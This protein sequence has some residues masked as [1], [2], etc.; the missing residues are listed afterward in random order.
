MKSKLKNEIQRRINE[1]Y[2]QRDAIKTITKEVAQRK[3]NIRMRDLEEKG[4]DYIQNDFIEQN[5]N[6]VGDWPQ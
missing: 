4:P 6:V 2:G 1:M 3:R 5:L